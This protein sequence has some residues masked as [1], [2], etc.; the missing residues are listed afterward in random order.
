[1]TTNRTKPTWTHDPADDAYTLIQGD[2]RCRV[3]HT[4]QND[5][6]AAV[7]SVRGMFTA[8]YNFDTADAAKAWCE[9]QARGYARG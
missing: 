2:V 8:A 6:W 3:W 5:T 9:E 1:M 4:T 7:I